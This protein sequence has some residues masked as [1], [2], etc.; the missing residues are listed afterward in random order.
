MFDDIVVVA[1]VVENLVNGDDVVVDVA[2]HESLKYL[3]NF[4]LGFS[5]ENNLNR[6][7]LI[8]F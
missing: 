2:N 5:L 1:V 7:E 6:I 4:S 8:S 3:F